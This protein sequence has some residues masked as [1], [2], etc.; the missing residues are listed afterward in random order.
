MP[1]PTRHGLGLELRLQTVELE[2]SLRPPPF[3]TWVGAYGVAVDSQK[4]SAPVFHCSVGLPTGDSRGGRD[5]ATEES[6]LVDSSGAQWGRPGGLRL[7]LSTS[8]E[9][10]AHKSGVGL[11]REAKYGEGRR[12]ASFRYV[13]GLLYRCTPLLKRTTGAVC[14]CNLLSPS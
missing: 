9:K 1:L 2:K 3:Q 8:R 4:C 5:L 12:R 14:Y 13:V 11:H 7:V 10:A 6:P